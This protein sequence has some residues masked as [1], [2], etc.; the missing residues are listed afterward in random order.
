MKVKKIALWMGGA[1]AILILL[2]IGALYLV[3]QNTFVHRD[4]LAEIIRAG[5]KASGAKIAIQDFRIRWLPLHV[6]LRNVVVRGN[7]ENGSRPLANLPQVEIGIAW[8]ALLHKRVDLTELIVDRPDVN[9]MINDAGESN[10][11][12]RPASAGAQSK[13]SLQV[14]VQ[15]AEVRTGEIL[16]NNL[17]RK[18]DADLADF[19]LDVNQNGASGQYSGNLGYSKSEIA[20]DGRMP[21]RHDAQISFEATPTGINFERIHIET[22]SSQ[23][24]AKG[25]MQGY[26]I[27]LVQAQYQA[28]VSTADLRRGLPTVPL[29]GGE[30]ELDGSLSY[31]AAAGSVLEALKTSGH[32]SSKTLI[33]SASSTEVAFR[34]LG[35]DYS[36]EGG[37][38]RVNGVQAETMGG[39][40]HAEFS[41]EHLTATPR[42]QLSVSTGSLSLEQAKQAAG[43]GRVPVQGKAHLR[44]SAHWVA[45]VQNM[46]ARADA[47]ISAVINP[48][49]YS[50]ASTKAASLPVNAELHFT[51][52]APHSTLTV[53]NSTFSSN[54]TNITAAGTVSDHSALTIRARTSDLQETDLLILAAR[55][56]LSSDGKTPPAPGAPLNLHGRASLDAE[57]QG[58]IQSPRIMGH[59]EADALEIRQARWPHVQGDFDATASSVSVKNGLARN[60]NQ[61]RLNFALAI[62]LQHWSF[63]ADNSFT[64]QVQASQIA[65]ADLEQLTGSSAPVSGMFS[66]NLSARGTIANPA[67]EGSFQVQNASV[68][69]EP[70]RT[71][72]AQ[73]RAANKNVSA[74]FTIAA[75]AGNISGQA[76][77]GVSDRHYQ[78]SVS[79]SVLN[80]G[81]LRYLSSRGYLMAGTLGIEAHGQ[82]TLESPQ[83]DIALAA[84]QLAFRN[85]PIGSMDAQFHVANRQANFTFTSNVTGG[86]IN[87]NGNAGLTAPYMVHGAFEVRSLEFGP[88]LA[89]YVPGV[90]R[91]FKGNAEVRGQI[92]GP[93]VRP[94]EVKANVELSALKL[95]Y[96]DLALASVGPVRLN[97]ADSVLTIPEAEL[98]GTGTDFKFG[99]AL[100]LRGSAPANISTTGV[101]DLK[102]LTILGSNTQSSGTVRVDLTARGALKQ[103]QLGGT[104]ELTSASF[105]SDVAPVGIEN[106]NA[107]IGLANNRLTVENLSGKMGGGSFSVSGFANY[108][109]VSYSLQVT[110]KSIRIRYPE[111]TRSQVD[112]DLT[113]IGTPASSTL[114][115][116]VTI[117]ELS[118]TPVF[119]LA[120]FVGQI[121]SSTPSVPPQ[122]E[123]NMRLDVG[124][125]SSNVLALSNSQLSL[126]GSADLR[127][128][129]TLGHP[130]VLGRTMLTGGSLIF[131]NNVYQVQSGTVIFA[132]PVRTEPTL[133]LYVTTSVQQYNITLNFIGPM[134]RLRTNYMSDPAL[135]PV[136]IIHLL[137][138]GKTTEQAAATA[139]PASIGAESVIANG[140]TSQV[141]NRIEKLVGI[142]QLQIDPS[143]GGNN[144]NPGARVAIQQRLTSSILF[145]FATDLTNTQN[146]VVQM[147]YQTRRRLSIS[148]TRDEY[149]SYAIE[150]KTRKTF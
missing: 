136:D 87:A 81:Q 38:I 97:Y 113:I 6:T 99:G 43:A 80:L 102:L 47:G 108:S 44:A 68:W 71:I 37:T 23:L 41:G 28:L 103:P 16:Y 124:V 63:N 34:A 129:G 52:D 90:R 42:Y 133:N 5:E 121:S 114:N 74:N 127:V 134:D 56:I 46:I 94:E 33:A 140:L 93:L 139:T 89:T 146:E 105:I 126:Q 142:S 123:D 40:M 58:R 49:R 79:H 86:Q 116:R 98:K 149:G 88:L 75:A 30:I 70:V 150:V 92:D 27:P 107:R 141:S 17:P 11:P 65:I 101:I 55:N 85:T 82:G 125:A 29:S 35:G 109:P 145:T 100:P 120:N 104:I 135:P 2:V 1:V 117:D 106:V 76:E 62:S 111:G 77:F 4:L 144:S 73:I 132:N 137:A 39:V 61:G 143:L 51:Y 66:G 112:T 9:L 131:M 7:E 53:T 45:S 15:H 22:E 24:N 13:S 147:K 122:W 59:M 18:I 25:T 72:D 21:M 69:G 14:I 57:I 96:Q 84:R 26:S 67:G 78:V 130:V 32:V 54:Q 36:L 12:A 19:H 48:G 115:G 20:I 110:G 118:F 64:A 31:D 119:D 128:V 8:N 10:L 3:Q 83:L 50:A 60:A 91:P 95:G 138:F 148:L